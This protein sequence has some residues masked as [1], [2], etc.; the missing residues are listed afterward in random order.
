MKQYYKHLICDVCNSKV[1]LID[2]PNIEVLGATY[3]IHDRLV[4][5]F[6]C[7]YCKKMGTSIIYADHPYIHY[8]KH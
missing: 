4:V 7:P 2:N 6:E 8:D 1:F 3:D 5:K